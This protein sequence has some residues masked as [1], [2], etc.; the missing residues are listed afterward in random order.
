MNV[1][2]HVVECLDERLKPN[3]ISRQV[4]GHHEVCMS[5]CRTIVPDDFLTKHAPLQFLPHRPHTAA[6]V[7]AQVYPPTFFNPNPNGRT[8]SL[9]LAA[10]GQTAPVTFRTLTDRRTREEL[11][12][13]VPVKDYR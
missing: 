2:I 10:N 12:H 7:E 1:R 8:I 4:A 13:Y 9:P 6:V 5:H 11:S 3:D